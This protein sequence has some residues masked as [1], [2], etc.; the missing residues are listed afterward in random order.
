MAMVD[1]IPLA[2]RCA[3]LLAA[4]IL[5]ALGIAAAAPARTSQRLVPFGFMGVD[6]NDVL[7]DPSFG[8]QR[9]NSEFSQMVRTGVETVRIAVTWNAAQPYPNDA[10]VPP[11]QASRFQDVGG[12]PTD[13]ST[14]DRLYQAAAA[15]GLSVL[16]TIVQAPPWARLDP[17]KDWSPPADPAAFGRFAGDVAARYGPNGSF[18]QAHPE[19]RALPSNSWQIWNEPIGGQPGLPSEFWQDSAPPE[20]RYIA[21]LRASRAAIRAV[22][23]QGKVIFASLF[24][25]TWLDLQDFYD[26]GA[27]G[28]FDGVAVNMFTHR[29]SNIVLALTYT[30]HVMDR[31]G[32]RALPLT[33]TEFSWPTAKGLGLGY[34]ATPA[35]SAANLTSAI[36]QLVA[37]RQKLN[38]T[39]FFYYTWLSTDAGRPDKRVDL[40]DFAGIRYVNLSTMQI[41]A[42]PSQAAF[43]TAA[44]RL[45]GCRKTRIATACG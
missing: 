11:G 17:K 13:W 1:R 14:S 30:R 7:V 40:F 36:R 28:L 31:N 10:A 15:H 12:V 16:P 29:A 6:A 4:V 19:L 35:Q 41:R 44:R 20:A 5:V 27:R 3:L 9:L 22:D 32:G 18:W 25:Y 42:R 8:D 26:H 45:E 23:P 24:G 2:H 39:G 43:T 21:M 38:L 34:N 37:A 33:L